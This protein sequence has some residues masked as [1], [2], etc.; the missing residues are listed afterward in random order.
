MLQCVL[1]HQIQLV[2][3]RLIYFQTAVFLAATGLEGGDTVKIPEHIG[4][5]ERDLYEKLRSLASSPPKL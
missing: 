3:L 2:S 4:P 5:K 1:Y